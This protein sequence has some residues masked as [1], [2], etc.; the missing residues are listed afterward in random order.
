M[1]SPTKRDTIMR[2]STVSVDNSLTMSMKSLKPNALLKRLDN[3]KEN[4]VNPMPNIAT[5][6]LDDDM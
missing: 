2:E 3:V 6:M 4:K 5:I 1:P